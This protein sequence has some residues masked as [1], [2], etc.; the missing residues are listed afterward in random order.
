VNV[1]TWNFLQ[2]V[3]QVP[4]IIAHGTPAVPVIA[5]AL[6]TQQLLVSLFERASPDTPSLNVNDLLWEND[7]TFDQM[8]LVLTPF[9]D[10]FL[11][12]YLTNVTIPGGKGPTVKS[13]EKIRVAVVED[14][15]AS[16]HLVGDSL[17][18]TLSF[19]GQTAGA[20]EDSSSPTAGNFK[21]YDWG[22]VRD[23]IDNP[24]PSQTINQQITQIQKFKPHVVI[25]IGAKPTGPNLNGFGSIDWDPKDPD[26]LQEDPI[27]IV[28]TNWEGEIAGIIADDDH[29]RR[30]T[31]G[32]STWGTN[33]NP[34]NAKTWQLRMEKAFPELIGHR[35]STQAQPQEMYD[36]LKMLLYA[37]YAVGNRPITAK[38]IG[39][40][41]KLLAPSGGSTNPIF[42]DTYRAITQALAQGT[43][44]A[45]QGLTG[46]QLFDSRDVRQGVATI[47]CFDMDP[48]TK[49]TT[50]ASDSGFFFDISAK[51][52]HGVVSCY[53]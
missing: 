7:V 10:S 30:R 13:G 34:D 22:N 9:F 16:E 15:T 18:T 42:I 51:Q 44:V 35:V 33:R 48:S 6:P 12:N 41:M 53:K 32:S 38:N 19:N 14:G 2:N 29:L 52:A 17:R 36:T 40:A 46:L 5:H 23:V 43:T 31:F 49:L 11:G 26:F 39:Q 25:F 45:I 21:V 27:Y 4:A 50:G 20:Q 1:A 37:T 3:V 24:V 8:G 47:D 28:P